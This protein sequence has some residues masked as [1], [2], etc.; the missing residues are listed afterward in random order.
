MMRARGTLGD[1]EYRQLVTCMSTALAIV[2]G[3]YPEARRHSG[4]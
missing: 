1:V 4:M 3:V 2:E